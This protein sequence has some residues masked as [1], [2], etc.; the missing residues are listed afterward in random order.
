M[1]GGVATSGAEF[2]PPPCAPV[3]STPWPPRLPE[4]WRGHVLAVVEGLTRTRLTQAAAVI[5]RRR[6]VLEDGPRSLFAR[7]GA[8]LDCGLGATAALALKDELAV[9]GVAADVF[10]TAR[11]VACPRALGVDEIR[12]DD[13]GFR[14]RTELGVHA[15]AWR[16]VQVGL[17]ATLGEARLPVLDLL[18]GQWER[19]RVTEAIEATPHA[20]R[21]G[22]PTLAKLAAVVLDRVRDLDCNEAL[23]TL[24][25]GRPP[26]TPHFADGLD[27]E[28]WTTLWLARS[29]RAKAM[30]RS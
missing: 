6:G 25:I 17:L 28:G 5:A 27:H 11:V 21:E 3:P 2:A 18:T 13:A 12:W 7:T 22:R 15:V 29:R 19:F 8:V 26:H 9:L 1:T 16:D 20:S 23:T 24:S 4:W 14:L 10:D 30:P